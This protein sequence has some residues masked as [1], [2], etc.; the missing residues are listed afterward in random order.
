MHEN[1]WG[2]ESLAPVWVETKIYLKNLNS[3]SLIQEIISNMWIHFGYK[4]SFPDKSRI[5]WVFCLKYFNGQYWQRLNSQHCVYLGVSV[6]F[7]FTLL[8]HHCFF[9]SDGGDLQHSGL[10]VTSCFPIPSET[11]HLKEFLLEFFGFF[12][13][14]RTKQYEEPSLALND[15]I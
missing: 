12:S 11:L 7:N 6:D 8:T 9:S 5:V 4:D 14:S 3:W 13:F 2:K 1:N 10:C 15:A